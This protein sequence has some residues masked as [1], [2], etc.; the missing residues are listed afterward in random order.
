MKNNTYM[1]V[2]NCPICSVSYGREEES[3]QA[4]SRW[5][6]SLTLEERMEFLC[7]FT[8]LVLEQNPKIS[9]KKDAQPIKG[10]F[11]IVSGT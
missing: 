8:D 3:L 1:P 4:K 2:N 5:F 7:S 9:D 6:K 10:T 11:Q